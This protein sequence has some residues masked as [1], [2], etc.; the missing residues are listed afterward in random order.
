[1]LH[2]GSLAAVRRTTRPTVQA[3]W[4]RLLASVLLA[5]AGHAAAQNTTT[6]VVSGKTYRVWTVSTTYSAYTGRFRVQPWFTGS[7]SVTDG[8]TG[9]VLAAAFASSSDNLA[10]Q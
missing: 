10:T 6:V 8:N 7:A 5:A 3:A 4:P 2:A 1:M 9:T